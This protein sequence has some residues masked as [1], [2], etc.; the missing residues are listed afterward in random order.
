MRSGKSRPKKTC[1]VPRSPRRGRPPSKPPPVRDARSR[2]NSS[3]SRLPRAGTVLVAKIV[4]SGPSRH[5]RGRS[6]PGSPDRIRTS[7]PDQPSQVAQTLSRCAKSGHPTII[8][9]GRRTQYQMPGSRIAV[10]IGERRSSAKRGPGCPICRSV[11]RRLST[12]SGMTR[13]AQDHRLRG[14]LPQ[15]PK[16]CSIARRPLISLLAGTKNSQIRRHRGG[17]PGVWTTLAL[18]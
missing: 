11:V 13:A 1:I 18:Q 6:G 17:N 12:G 3:T 7:F 9:R 14:I 15:F 4:R 5:P 10:D 16:L 8:A 2:R